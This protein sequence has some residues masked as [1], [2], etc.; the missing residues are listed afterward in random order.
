MAN[1]R[2]T[3]LIFVN[4]TASP[5]PALD[6][7]H[8]VAAAEDLRLDVLRCYVTGPMRPNALQDLVDDARS[9]Q[10]APMVIVPR[11]EPDPL[12][13]IRQACT[14]LAACTGETFPRD[15]LSLESAVSADMTEVRA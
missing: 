10:V 4:R 11:V 15:G 6:L 8:A 9:Q 14:V 3:A 7:R 5:D 1:P 12:D 2:P 13:F